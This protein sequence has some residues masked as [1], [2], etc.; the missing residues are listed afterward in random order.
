MPNSLSLGYGLNLTP[1][2]SR[3]E[4][5]EVMVCAF[6][7]LVIK[8]LWFPTS[9]SGSLAPRKPAAILQEH[10]WNSAEV[11]LTMNW[12]LQPTASR[13]IPT[14]T[15]GGLQPLSTFWLQLHTRPRIRTNQLRRTCISDPQRLC[16]II[17]VKELRFGVHF[18]CSN[19][20][21]IQR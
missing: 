12:S 18:P 6:G 4:K 17:N 19:R 3:T 11:H 10:F 15:L 5:G 7:H 1:F 16:E 8:E 13:G 14:Q 9:L 20:L 21:L 2:I